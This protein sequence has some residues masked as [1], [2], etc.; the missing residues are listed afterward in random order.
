MPAERRSQW[1]GNHFWLLA[2][3]IVLSLNYSRL[4][5]RADKLD[6]VANVCFLMEATLNVFARYFTDITPPDGDVLD[7]T[8]LRL[9]LVASVFWVLNA[10]FYL[11]ANV[12]RLCDM[13]KHVK[14][15]QYEVNEH[16][17]TDMT[18]APEDP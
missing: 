5:S 2:A 10:F 17:I 13:W 6:V 8:E 11:C 16:P 14:T 18:E 7:I 15:V 9:E 3:I 12:C 4:Q 1:V